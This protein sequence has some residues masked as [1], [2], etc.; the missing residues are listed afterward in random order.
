MRSF[1]ELSFKRIEEKAK[2]IKEVTDMIDESKRKRFIEGDPLMS[3][4]V[5]G[6]NSSK[7]P[8]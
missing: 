2:L 1:R 8:D 5:D 4:G 6:E 7:V 3:D